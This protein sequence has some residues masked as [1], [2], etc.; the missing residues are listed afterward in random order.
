MEQQTKK[1]KK[2]AKDE[3]LKDQKLEEQVNG[4]AGQKTNN[5]SIDRNYDGLA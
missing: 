3:K 5:S 4:M 2:E 1:S